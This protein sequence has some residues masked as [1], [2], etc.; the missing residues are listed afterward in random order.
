VVFREL[1]KLVRK[2]EAVSNAGQGVNPQVPVRVL[3]TLCC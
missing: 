2:D 1:V 3:A